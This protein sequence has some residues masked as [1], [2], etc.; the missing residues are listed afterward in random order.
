MGLFPVTQQAAHMI[1]TDL[2]TLFLLFVVAICVGFA[3]FAV[4]YASAARNY[5]EDC[6]QWVK[7][8]NEKSLSLTRIAELEAALTD[9]A[10]AYHALLKSHKKLRS[11][12]GMREL[13]KRRKD[14]QNGSEEP[15][16]GGLPLTKEQLRD[17]ARKRNMLR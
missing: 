9:L 3:G 8:N 12:I 17:E 2:S 13:R 1:S 14:A 4:K 6:F 16:Q 10:D 7:G 11:R 15:A 5:A